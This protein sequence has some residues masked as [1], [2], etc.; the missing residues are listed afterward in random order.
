MRRV[1]KE[2]TEAQI[3]AYLESNHV[4]VETELYE[5]LAQF[6]KEV[7]KTIDV[8]I[9]VKLYASYKME[10]KWKQRYF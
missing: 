3:R 1:D 4:L 9:L 2:L 10:G 6:N 5:F 8:D 7:L